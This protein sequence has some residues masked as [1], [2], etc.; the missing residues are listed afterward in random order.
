[1]ALPP[2]RSR[3]RPPGRVLPSS[4]FAPAAAGE[5]RPARLVSGGPTSSTGERW[6]R[7]QSTRVS[8]CASPAATPCRSLRRASRSAPRPSLLQPPT[9]EPSQRSSPASRRHRPR[10]SR[11][12]PLLVIATDAPTTSMPTV[13]G[14]AA[15]RPPPPPP[16]SPP[17][18]AARPTP[19][20]PSRPPRNAVSPAAPASTQPA[21]DVPI[22]RCAARHGACGHDQQQHDQRR[23]RRQRARVEGRGGDHRFA[24]HD[25]VHRGRCR[26]SARRAPAAPLLAD[27]WA[28]LDDVDARRGPPHARAPPGAG[29]GELGGDPHRAAVDPRRQRRDEGP[30]CRVGPRRSGRA[31][32]HPAPSAPSVGGPLVVGARRT[33]DPAVRCC[34]DAPRRTAARRVRARRRAPRAVH[35]CADRGG[36]PARSRRCSRAGCSPSTPARRCPARRPSQ[37]GARR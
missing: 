3:T 18:V 34:R 9:Q 35:R 30:P 37:G 10:A 13:S 33:A 25:A 27:A 6:N 15:D 22:V 32:P 31:E 12:R 17:A 8:R 24:R 19:E 20:P 29:A 11:A 26:P 7:P 4:G 2:I 1:M 36:E 23:L 5:E 28:H 21:A 16:A 14:D